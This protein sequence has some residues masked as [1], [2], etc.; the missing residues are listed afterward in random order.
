MASSASVVHMRRRASKS[1]RV[2][3]GRRWRSW[4]ARRL[5]HARRWAAAPAIRSCSYPRRRARPAP[6]GCRTPTRRRL[7]TTDPSTPSAPCGSTTTAVRR[8]LSTASCSWKARAVPPPLRG[9]KVTQLLHSDLVPWQTTPELHVQPLSMVTAMP[10]THDTCSLVSAEGPHSPARWRALPQA[11][12]APQSWRSPA[13][14]PQRHQSPPWSP[15]VRPSPTRRRMT[16][17]APRWLC[18]RTTR[19]RRSGSRRRSASRCIHKHR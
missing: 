10:C 11:R 8:K 3:C 18:G 15:C 9:A 7:P 13:R 19:L 5:R 16:A 1:W 14:E 2:A 4:N 17:T 6:P 12:F